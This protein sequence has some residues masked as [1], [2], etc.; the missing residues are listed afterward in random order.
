MYVSICVFGTKG[1]WNSPQQSHCL[2]CVLVAL[3]RDVPDLANIGPRD[4]SVY[5]HGKTNGLGQRSHSLS[6]VACRQAKHV[7]RKV[8]TLPAAPFVLRHIFL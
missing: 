4:T 8:Q 5:S 2:P 7:V 3:R 6:R 1:R